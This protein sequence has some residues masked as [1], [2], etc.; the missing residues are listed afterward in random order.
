MR[1]AIEQVIKNIFLMIITNIVDI[2]FVAGS[3]LVSIGLFRLD[4]IIGF[5]GTGLLLMLVS[6]LLF[7]GGE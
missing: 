1:Q 4:S 2:T 5:I 6:F 3:I 7:K